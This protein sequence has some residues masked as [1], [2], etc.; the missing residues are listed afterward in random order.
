MGGYYT[1]SGFDREGDREADR[2]FGQFTWTREWATPRKQTTTLRLFHHGENSRYHSAPAGG[3]LALNLASSPVTNPFFPYDY[4]PLNYTRD[5]HLRSSG[6]GATHEI[7]INDRVSAAAGFDLRHDG[8]RL[9][10]YNTTQHPKEW[11]LGLFAETDIKLTD[12]LTLT[13]GLRGD[14]TEHFRAE[15]SPRAALLWHA[16]PGTEF[17]ASAT[18]AFR[19]PGLSDRYIDTVSIY[20][21]GSPL[22]IALPYK[23]NPRLKPTNIYA[24]ET[25]F[26]QRFENPVDFVR[27]VEISAALFY[28]DIR[29]DFDF[30]RGVTP[31]GTMEMQVVNA[32]RAYTCGG[33]V[34]LRARFS[35]G[36]EFIGHA[37][38][39]EGRY[40]SSAIAP[41][42]FN[43]DIKGNRLANLAPWKLGAGIQ[44]NSGETVKPWR[45][46]NMSHGLFARFTDKRYAGSDNTVRLR[47]HT[48]FDW[49]SRVQINPNL[50]LTLTVAN[51][52]NQSYNVYDIISPSGYPAPG[53]LWMLGL[54]GKF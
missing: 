42:D 45:G 24:Y 4:L 7:E 19:T 51:V 11:S 44:W 43:D 14:K 54:E 20:Y 2:G 41:D 53:R 10:D 22:A 18:K 34:E 32:N 47:D 35:R 38:Y 40:K 50:G 39:N 17:Y 28:N 52:F 9:R 21:P 3:S 29:D 46:F 25:G 12:T 5:Y 30:H 6:G 36:F 48:V 27:R 33:E 8:A 26:R 23:G 16:T 15:P 13:L 49:S 1:G 37:S 31:F